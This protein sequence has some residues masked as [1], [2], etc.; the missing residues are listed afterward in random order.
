[1]GQRYYKDYSKYVNFWGRFFSNISFYLPLYVDSPSQLLLLSKMSNP[2]SS[3]QYNSALV[4]PFVLQITIGNRNHSS[5][6]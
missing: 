6:E 4:A 1:M 5:I 2:F 3:L